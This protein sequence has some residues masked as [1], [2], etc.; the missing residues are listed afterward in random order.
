MNRPHHRGHHGPAPPA[1]PYFDTWNAP[2]NNQTRAVPLTR[3][4]GNRVGW[5]AALV[6]NS[7]SGILYVSIDR[8]HVPSSPAGADYVVPARST[9]TIPLREG[10][11]VALL[12]QGSPATNDLVSTVLSDDPARIS[13]GLAPPAT[14]TSDVISPGLIMQYGGSGV[15]A[16]GW[17]VCDGSAVSRT[18]YAALFAVCGTTF[19][20]G[21]GS[22]TFNLPDLRG[23]SIVGT[24]TGAGL[25]NRALGATGGEENHL[26]STA[27]MPTHQHDMMGNTTNPGVGDGHDGLSGNQ[28]PDNA[29]GKTRPA[30]GGAVHNNM[31]PFLAL[32]SYIKT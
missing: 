24:G 17:L 21:D 3:L 16:G 2:Q 18:V 15:P 30:G 9:S 29:Q 27:E 1:G 11:G 26:L 22:T 10:F 13:A 8:D 28:G 4:A 12:W 19:G 14:V 7:T 32:P 6:V 23:R 20:A 5:K 25:T 31:H